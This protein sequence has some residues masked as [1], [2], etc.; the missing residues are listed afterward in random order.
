MGKAD[1]ISI[2]FAKKECSKY[3]V[4]LAKVKGVKTLC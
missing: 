2:D 3:F 1:F 4:I